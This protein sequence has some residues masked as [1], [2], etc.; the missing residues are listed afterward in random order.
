MSCG[1]WCVYY[2]DRNNRVAMC[3]YCPYYDAG[4]TKPHQELEKTDTYKL[5]HG[6][7]R[8]RKDEPPAKLNKD[9]KLEICPKCGLQT[10]WYNN[11][12]KK[13]ECMNKW[14]PKREPPDASN[15]LT[16]NIKSY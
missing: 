13:F 3:K 12:D 9:S 11:Q 10:L 7:A 8:K 2:K 1:S 16:K 5:A 14:C 15:Y 6:L 4:S